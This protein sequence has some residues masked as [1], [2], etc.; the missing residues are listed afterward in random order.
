M[1]C[2]RGTRP[3]GSAPGEQRHRHRGERRAG[4]AAGG[5]EQSALQQDTPGEGGGRGAQRQAHGELRQ[6]RHPAGEQEVGEV[7]AGQQQHEA[8]RAT[9]GGPAVRI[10][11]IHMRG[12]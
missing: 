10:A 2:E 4:H 1:A 12:Q 7:G 8:D 3:A 11:G 6:A 5:G 9:R